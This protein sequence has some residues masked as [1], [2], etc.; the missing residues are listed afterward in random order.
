MVIH[1]AWEQAGIHRERFPGGPMSRVR[2]S[3]LIALLIAASLTAFLAMSH[4]H[5]SRDRDAASAQD[6]ATCRQSLAYLRNAGTIAPSASST[7]SL[8]NNRGLRDAAVA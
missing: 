1:P 5:A 3:L 6:L 8:D 4:L 7:N 2:T